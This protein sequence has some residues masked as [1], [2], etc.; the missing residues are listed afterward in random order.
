MWTVS[1]SVNTWKEIL[2]FIR[3][4]MTILFDC[5]DILFFFQYIG[6]LDEMVINLQKHPE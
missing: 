2:I 4:Q 3:L 6:A 1:L 5:Y